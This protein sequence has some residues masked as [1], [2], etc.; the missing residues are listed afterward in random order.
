[1]K[2]M[3][4]LNN[5]LRDRLK[6][7]KDRTE[8]QTIVTKAKEVAESFKQLK[9]ENKVQK[10]LLHEFRIMKKVHSL[11]DFKKVIRTCDFWADTW[12]V[13]TLERILKIK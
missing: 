6:Q 12:A 5:E 4:K 8:Q 2:K 13:S 7:S 11:D 9:R 1:M 10:S 3:S